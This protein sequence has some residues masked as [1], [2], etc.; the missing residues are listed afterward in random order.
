MGPFSWCNLVRVWLPAL[1][2]PHG[3]LLHFTAPPTF[4]RF[5]SCQSKFGGCGG[6]LVLEANASCFGE[7]GGTHCLAVIALAGRPVHY[8]EWLWTQEPS[9]PY[10]G[11]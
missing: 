6:H 10:T 2:T 11:S 9:M 1:P 8:H 4:L 3:G 5:S 7:V